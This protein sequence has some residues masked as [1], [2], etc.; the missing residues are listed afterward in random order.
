[1]SW[2][3]LPEWIYNPWSTT[4]WNKWG[5]EVEQVTKDGRYRNRDFDDNLQPLPWQP[6]PHPIAQRLRDEGKLE[7]DNFRSRY[8]WSEKKQS[9]TQQQPE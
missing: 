9:Q 1:M 6:G 3:T 8:S 4:A 2:F 7:T 5:M